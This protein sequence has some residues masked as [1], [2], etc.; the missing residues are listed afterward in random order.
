MLLSARDC[1][2]V[3]IE[4]S[5]PVI[6]INGFNDFEWYRKPK[7]RRKGPWF[8]CRYEFINE[9][10]WS[11]IK[12]CLYFLTEDSGDLKFSEEKLKYVGKTV[13]SL[14]K[15]WKTAPAYDV[16]E[17][18]LK[19]KEMFHSEC[20]RH[21]CDAKKEGSNDKF[22]VSMIQDTELVKVLSNVNHEISGLSVFK[23]AP[24][25]VVIAMEG[26]FIKRF[27]STLWN[28]RR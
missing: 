22:I 26:W 6:K 28:K 19:K 4:A 23:N 1:A 12:P 5:H 27:M 3:I 7:D 17:K 14:S 13:N 9:K 24:E 18:L 15:R 16:D 25:I 11:E 2:S 8:Q 21:M 20:M 10:L